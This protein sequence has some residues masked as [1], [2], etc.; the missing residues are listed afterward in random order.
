MTRA[1]ATPSYIP[2]SVHV[3]HAREE[4]GLSTAIPLVI[5]FLNFWAHI[6]DI[7]YKEY[8][9]NCTKVLPPGR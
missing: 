6:S 1:S 8:V 3:K 9:H 2:S 4:N 7:S 5:L